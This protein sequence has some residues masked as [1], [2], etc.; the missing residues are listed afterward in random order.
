MYRSG[1]LLQEQQRAPVVPL[2]A[3]LPGRWEG[4]RE[5]EM[6]MENIQ[7]HRHYVL[8][9]YAQEA[10]L[11]VPLRAG[12]EEGEEQYPCSSTSL[13]RQRLPQLSPAT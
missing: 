10:P 1:W 7:S 5:T 8:L 11:E 12:G 9:L 3:P 13:L 6:K 2:A 4:R